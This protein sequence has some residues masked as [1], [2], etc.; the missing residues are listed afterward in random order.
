MPILQKRPVLRKRR[1]ETVSPEVARPEGGISVE[2]LT[3]K[4]FNKSLGYYMKCSGCCER[5]IA[6]NECEEFEALVDRLG[7]IEEIL[8]NDYDL[9]RLRELV[10]VRDTLREFAEDVARQFG[11]HGTTSN[12]R[13]AYT[14]GGLSTLEWAWSLLGWPDPRPAPECECQEDGCHEWATSGRPTPDGYKWLCGRHF[15]AYEA[16]EDAEA[17]LKG[18]QHEQNL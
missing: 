12:G 4:H 11:Y 17:A 10:E 15:A 5:S 16:R 6:C 2:R 9:D 1:D 7:A 3:D 8:G 14:T 18:D 13:P